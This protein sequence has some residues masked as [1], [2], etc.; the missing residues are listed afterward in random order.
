MDKVEVGIIVAMEMELENIEK[1]MTDKN[2]VQLS[3][4]RFIVGTLSG[5][6]VV[7]AQC[8]I[9]KVFAAICTQTMIL[10]FSPRIIINTG[11]AGGLSKNLTI[12]E[13]V[14]AKNAVQHDMDTT[15]LGDEEGLISGLNIVY[16]P[17]DEKATALLE[18]TAEKLNIKHETGTIATGDQFVHTSDV[19]QRLVSKF[20][21]LACDMESG[22]IAHTCY[23]N[24]TPCAVLR[25]ISDGGD[26]NSHVDYQTFA[27]EAAHVSAAV[28]TEFVGD[29]N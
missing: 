4:M 13:L 6:R 1:E 22:S 5:K 25:A 18:A 10:T 29:F 3:G 12:G 7:A 14:I 20:N 2:V 16:I 21:A 19:K 15:P 24:K 26:E 9:G 17:T 11:V 27:R 8:G 28:I 23:V